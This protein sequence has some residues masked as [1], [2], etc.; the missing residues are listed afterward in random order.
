MM[1]RPKFPTQD[2]LIGRRYLRRADGVPK[3]T[4]RTAPSDRVRA[5]RKWRQAQPSLP[6]AF[7]TKCHWCE[8][9]RAHAEAGSFVLDGARWLCD[10]CTA[11]NHA[12]VQAEARAAHSLD[13]YVHR[14][15]RIGS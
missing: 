1:I 3:I 15:G 8:S 14:R 12:S 10:L 4:A 7:Q 6:D 5:L 11:D 9:D 2:N 13:A